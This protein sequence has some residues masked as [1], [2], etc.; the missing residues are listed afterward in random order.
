[1]KLKE[2]EG[3]ILRWEKTP[4][5]LKLNSISGYFPKIFQTSCLTVCSKHIN[6]ECCQGT[7]QKK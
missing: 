4:E 2:H 7:S 5:L 6:V 3:W 1:M